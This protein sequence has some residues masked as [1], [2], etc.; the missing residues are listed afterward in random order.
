MYDSAVWKGQNGLSSGSGILESDFFNIGESW[1]SEKN[2]FGEWQ[3][4]DNVCNIFGN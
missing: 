1:R 3:S 4:V 2:H